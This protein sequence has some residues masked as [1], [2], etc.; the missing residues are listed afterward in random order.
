MG[1]NLDSSPLPQSRKQKI[2]RRY[3]TCF[4]IGRIYTLFHPIHRSLFAGLSP[5]AVSPL[6]GAPIDS[7]VAV[8]VLEET[9]KNI[10]LEQR[11]GESRR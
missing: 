10:S 6:V 11:D 1:Q 4:F 7:P 2:L 9:A 8:C 5:V 3:R